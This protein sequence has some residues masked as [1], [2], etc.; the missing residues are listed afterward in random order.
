MWR[1]NT[2][3]IR[4]AHLTAAASN[5][6]LLCLVPLFLL[7]FPLIILSLYNMKHVVFW[8]ACWWMANLFFSVF[9]LVG[10]SC[11]FAVDSFVWCTCRMYSY[12]PSQSPPGGHDD[13]D[14]TTTPRVIAPQVGASFYFDLVTPFAFL[15]FCPSVYIILGLL[16]LFS[17]HTWYVCTSEYSF[18]YFLFYFFLY[19]CLRFLSF[20]AIRPCLARRWGDWVGSAT[21]LLYGWRPERMRSG[22]GRGGGRS[23]DEIRKEIRQ[24]G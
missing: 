1:I 21:R 2:Y 17:L 12:C 16:H 11:C 15:A 24:A 6:A 18:I 10:G 22:G 9:S 5:A 20:F 19:F 13:S 8:L 23:I 7:S 3:D 4:T 14:A